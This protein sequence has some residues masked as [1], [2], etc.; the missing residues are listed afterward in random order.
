MM[1]KMVKDLADEI[2]DGRLSLT[3][4][5]KYPIYVTNDVNSFIRFLGGYEL[6]PLASSCAASVAQLL[7]PKTLP[8]QQITSFKHTL[9][10]V[11]P[12]LG[13][14]ESFAEVANIQKK[15]WNLPEAVCSP[16][17]KFS[18]PSDWRA[19]DSISTRPRRDKKPVKL[20]VVEGY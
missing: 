16:S 2:C 14:V 11:K 18:L 9:N 7:P 3:L 10:A 20:P 4:E 13:A 15:Y 6:Q 17:F 8:D 5:G 12:N 1:T 19:T